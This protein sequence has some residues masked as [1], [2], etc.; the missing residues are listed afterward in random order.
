MT[1]A[2]SGK[3]IEEL[4]L[5]AAVRGELS[6][7]DVSIG[8]ETLEHQAQI[9]EENGNPQL[10]ANLRRAAELTALD[11][12][13]VLRIYESLRPGRSSAEELRDVESELQQRGAT[14]CAALVGEAR[15]AYE[16]RG[17]LR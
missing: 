7:A 17:L 11:D 13:H 8:A 15:A 16:R 6:L 4:T 5:A 1:R 3:P 14:R 2:A 10:A 9:A 12:E